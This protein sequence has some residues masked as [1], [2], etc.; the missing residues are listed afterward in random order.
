MLKNYLKIAWRNLKRNK[1]YASI[2]IAGLAIGIASCLLI[3]LFIRYELSFDKFHRKAQ[4]IYRVDMSN[5][6][7]GT[8]M[9]PAAAKSG[10]TEYP[11]VKKSVRLYRDSKIVLPKN[12]QPIHEK[13]FY[14][15]DSTFFKIFSFPLVYG[16][17]STALSKPNS[18]VLT[19]SAAQKYFG[20]TNNAIGKYVKLRNGQTFKVTGIAE[21]V[22]HN[23]TIQF[24]MLASFASLGKSHGMNYQGFL[25]ILFKNS[26]D[27]GSLENKLDVFLKSNSEQQIS[28]RFGF[29]IKGMGFELQ[30]LTRIHL[31]PALG[32]SIQ[33]KGN[34]RLLY[35][36]GAIGIIILLISCINYMNLATAA[37]AKR[38]REVG[39]RKVLGANRRQ[40]AAQFLGES[41][42]FTAIAYLIALA[43][44]HLLL[45]LFAS[46]MGNPLPF[47]VINGAFAGFSILF[48]LVIGGFSGIYPAVILSRF[49][50]RRILQGIATKSH[51]KTSLRDK[52]VI[53]QFAAAIALIIGT[54]IIQHQLHFIR[55][56]PLGYKAQHILT[57]PFTTPYYKRMNSKNRKA[58]QAHIS[59]VKQA[60]AGVRGV[61]DVAVA[62]GAPNAHII[63]SVTY[64][65]R[66]YKYTELPVGYNYIPTMKMKLIAGRN[67]SKAHGTDSAQAIIVNQTAA[68]IFHLKDKTGEPISLKLGHQKPILIG[69][70]KDFHT[71]SFHY[72]I[73]PTVM[74]IQPVFFN[75]YV[76]RIASN[77]LPDV[78]NRLRKRWHN[79]FP[80]YPFTYH[81]LE[82]QLN[83]QYHTVQRTGELSTIFSILAVI[84]ACL[85]LFSLSSYAAQRRTKEIGIRKVLG[86]SEASIVRLLS[87]D[88]LKLVVIGFVIAVPIGWYAMH[89]WLQ[90]FAYKINMSWWIFLLA[91]GIALVIALATVSWQSV[92]A[93]LANPVDSLRQ[94]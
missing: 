73:R 66:K 48:I 41:I 18:I 74:V 56:Q 25:F 57:V 37:S 53:F 52:L 70:V 20:T 9:I 4:H 78:M 34:V 72:A 2:N 16:N 90:N 28:Q 35:I 59:T 26:K 38:A 12:H 62:Y 13:G 71:A 60:L 58:E 19:K 85:G 46:M 83:T 79:L 75:S 64:Q 84:I 39:M 32:G 17:S 43:I 69:I 91:G 65:G 3:F 40:I 7:G 77:S 50:P 92:R 82:D 22:P 76:I 29:W 31:Y 14:Y 11:G 6:F 8:A 94:E 47:F 44:A 89:R 80:D 15:A 30:P 27:A 49:S 86:A 68:R 1:S 10:L 45:P 21:D 24:D 87:K 36:L 54:I 5:G 93:A 42:L 33:P 67:F 51:S 81:F 88:F 23:S 63:S 55:K 61:K